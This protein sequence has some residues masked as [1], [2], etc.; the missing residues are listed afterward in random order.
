M[1]GVTITMKNKILSLSSILVA[2]AAFL[3]LAP[4]QLK[5]QT[6]IGSE[7][8]MPK[9]VAQPAPD[10]S[11]DLRRDGVEGEVVVSFVVTPSGEV[12][13]PV[14][15]SSTDPRLGYPTLVALRNWKYLPATRAG[16][17]IASRVLETVKYK[18][19]DAS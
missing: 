1:E 11:L 3:A 15:V 5:A 19:S 9:P 4:T 12:S 13:H 17:P 10:Y 14:I 16:I 18:M 6:I 2:S 8:K 7:V